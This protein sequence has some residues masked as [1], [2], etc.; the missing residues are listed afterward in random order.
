MPAKKGSAPQ[1]PQK[2]SRTLPKREPLTAEDTFEPPA[3]AKKTK[4]PTV[5]MQPP[6]HCHCTYKDYQEQQGNFYLVG[7]ELFAANNGYFPV[8]KDALEGYYKHLVAETGDVGIALHRIAQ[9]LDLYIND[10]MIET[11]KASDARNPIGRLA[12]LARKNPYNKKTYLDVLKEQRIAAQLKSGSAEPT[13]AEEVE[14]DPRAIELFGLGY[15]PG[16]Y[17][18][19]IQ[20]YDMLKK[21]FPHVDHVQEAAIKDQCTTK[22]MQIRARNDPDMYAKMTKLYQESLRNGPLSTLGDNSDLT[23][24]QAC[25]GVWKS[26]IEQHCPA[27]IY[28]NE[29]LYDDVDSLKEYFDRF[30][31]RPII[32]FFSG[33]KQLDEEFSLTPEEMSDGQ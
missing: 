33:R 17:A 11:V 1:R 29:K 8:S 19:L 26:Q 16:E 24:D 18:I 28:L 14:A 30:I 10:D 23:D 32:N 12:Q 27:E 21:Q 31:L 4:D 20:H 7:G 6:Y 15:E 13:E 3:F 22:L 2:M 25:F 5:V 9:Y